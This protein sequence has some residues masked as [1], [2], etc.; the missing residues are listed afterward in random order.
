V[1]I[2]PA[3][4]EAMRNWA[5]PTSVTELRVFFGID[6]YYRKFV[7]DY[8]LLAQS[9]SLT[10]LLKKKQFCWST[11]AQQSFDRLKQAMSSTPVL[12]IPNFSKGK[13]NCAANALSRMVH[14]QALQ[15]VSEIKP[16]WLQ[17][18]V[19]SYAI[20]A[21]AQEILAKLAVKSPDEQGIS[22]SQGLIRYNNKVWIT[23]NSALQTKVIAA[24]HS[25]DIGGHSGTKATYYR[26]K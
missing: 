26:V 11:V 21:Q 8:V 22:L 9:L 20:D 5:H 14:L 3:K 1:A 17:E 16:L 4:T 25:S 23:N 6:G 18:V 19:N 12:P 7:N 13:E 24:L 2:D 15:A 10:Q